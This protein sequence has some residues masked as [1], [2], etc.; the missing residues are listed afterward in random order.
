[1][2]FVKKDLNDS[3]WPTAQPFAM[4]S[5]PNFKTPNPSMVTANPNNSSSVNEITLSFVNTDSIKTDLMHTNTDEQLL[6][7]VS[8]WLKTI[9]PVKYPIVHK[10][11]MQLI[12]NKE[13]Y[14]LA[15]AN[16]QP[17]C[18]VTMFHFPEKDL[19]IA[20]ALYGDKPSSF[21]V[22]SQLALIYETVFNSRKI[23]YTSP[24]DLSFI[25]R[26]ARKH[27]GAGAA[28]RDDNSDTSLRSFVAKLLGTN[29]EYLRKIKAI[30]AYDQELLAWL[31][32]DLKDGRRLSVDEAFKMVPPKVN[33]PKKPI[34][35]KENGKQI[36]PANDL[37][38][39]NPT[40]FTVIK[41]IVPKNF[42]DALEQGQL[43]KGL[44]IYFASNSDKN[45]AVCL[46]FELGGQTVNTQIVDTQS[47][48]N[49]LRKVA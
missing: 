28:Y 20:R 49:A 41:Q 19:L 16:N 2:V 13:L 26:L 8:F 5:S 39:I 34:P 25:A 48:T 3:A 21:V 22:K 38:S 31:D 1:M 43:P 17:K 4:F 30:A 35:A 24:D 11:T 27:C 37:I 7:A 32:Q 33:N 18:E 47:L 12:G 42:A 15:I 23:D 9:F 10:G 29:A 14:D 6:K 45:P 36:V 40:T 44:S 46:T